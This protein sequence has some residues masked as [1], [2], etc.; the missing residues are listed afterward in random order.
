MAAY[1]LYEGQRSNCYTINILKLSKAINISCD[2][3]M[4]CLRRKLREAMRELEVEGYLRQLILPDR[5]K[6][7]AIFK[8]KYRSLTNYIWNF[9]NGIIIDRKVIDI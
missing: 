8:S 4:F 3:K 9:K 2:G 1:R 6:V 7:V 5:G